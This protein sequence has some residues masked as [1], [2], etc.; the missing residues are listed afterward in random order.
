MSRKM[1]LVE[2]LVMAV[3]CAIALY[4][5]TTKIIEGLAPLWRS[6][7]E[8]PNDTRNTVEPHPTA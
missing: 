8:Q 3:I 4:S 5:L 6:T 7:L 1:T 2:K